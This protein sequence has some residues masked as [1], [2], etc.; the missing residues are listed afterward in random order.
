MIIWRLEDVATLGK[1]EVYVRAH[2]ERGI[3]EILDAICHASQPHVSYF[4]VRLSVECITHVLHRPPRKPETTDQ[5]V[6]NLF[7]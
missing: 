1:S 6:Q 7:L 5:K 4:C 3:S 2:R